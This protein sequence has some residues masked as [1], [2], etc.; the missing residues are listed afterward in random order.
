MTGLCL[1]IETS[2]DET[3]A[4]VLETPAAIRSSVVSSQY[5]H[6]A[7][8]GVVPELAARAQVDPDV[9]GRELF[10]VASD[11]SRRSP[12]EILTTDF[13]EFRIDDKDWLLEQIYVMTRRRFK[14][15]R[16]WVKTKPHALGRTLQ[17][18]D[19]VGHFA[20]GSTVVVLL[21]RGYASGVVAR[22]E[23]RMGQ[24]LLHL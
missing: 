20:F 15:V 19:E 9:L 14:V 18:G 10:A 17:R 22:P 8:G 23:V 3:A 12:R 4:A 6:S 7:F 21:P 16:E 11:L 2:C 13:K 5:V 24:T 1:G